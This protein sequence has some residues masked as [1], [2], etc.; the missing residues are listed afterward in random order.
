MNRRCQMSKK[1]EDA[2][3]LAVEYEQKY[4]SCP[5]CVIAAVQDTIGCVSDDVFKSSHPLAGGGALC[6]DG[7]C[8]A[9]NGGM[10]AIGAK[11]G[12]DKNDFTSKKPQA[13]KLSRKLHD[14]FLLEYGTIFCSDVQEKLFGKS[15]NMW[16]VDEYREFEEKGGHRDKCPFVAGNVAKW[17]V[18]ILE[19]EEIRK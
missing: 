6:G 4:G 18:E 9:L 13:F 14:R 16:N 7:T 5:Q 12:R 1:S 8:G 15:F 11:F 10:L 19:E 3:R 2:Y 17:A